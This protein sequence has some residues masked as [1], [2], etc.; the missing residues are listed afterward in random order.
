MEYNRN[1]AYRR[2]RR[3][4]NGGGR[5]AGK[6]ILSLLLIAGI[7]YLIS[8][9]AAGTWLAEHVFAP[10]FEQFSD[11]PGTDDPGG[12]SLTVD[13]SSDKNAATADMTLPGMEAYLLQMGVY[14]SHDNA[15]AQAD[16]LKALGAGGY[17]YQDGDRYRVLAASYANAEDANVVKTRLISEGTDC[18]VFALSCEQATFRVSAKESELD[19]IRKGFSA[20]YTAQGSLNSTILKFDTESQSITE[21]KAAIDE[22]LVALQDDMAALLSYRDAGADVLESIL[23]CYDQ[24]Q[25]FLSDLTNSGAQTIVDFSSQMK[26]TQISMVHEYVKLTQEL[27]SSV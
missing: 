8:A 22:M 27:S 14:T 17:I 20:L 18:T 23:A 26:Y 12:N 16:R 5:A 1:K 6:I 19:A 15:T 3:R 21:G 4:G 25:A 13:F 24:Y 2:R 11:K 9:S 10:I 7:V